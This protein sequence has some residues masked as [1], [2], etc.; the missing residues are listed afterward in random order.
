M[1]PKSPE[2]TLLDLSR[3]LLDAIVAADFEKYKELVDPSLTSFEPESIGT[4]QRGL[5]FHQFGFSLGPFTSGGTL[6]HIELT[7]PHVRMLGEDAAVV[8][9]IRVDEMKAVNAPATA[10]SYEETRVWQRGGQDGWKL[11]HFHRSIPGRPPEP[12]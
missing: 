6:Y 11:V 8:T 12:K 7:S 3:Q 1:S 5:G 2:Q 4:F 10:T 9:Y